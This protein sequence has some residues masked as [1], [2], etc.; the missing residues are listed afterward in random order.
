MLVSLIVRSVARR[1]AC[2]RDSV[3][4][5]AADFNVVALTLINY[6]ESKD[7]ERATA[8]AVFPDEDSPVKSNELKD[9][10]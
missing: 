1:T 9:G 8:K 7:F 2:V 10:G 5:T 3:S 6:L 4:E